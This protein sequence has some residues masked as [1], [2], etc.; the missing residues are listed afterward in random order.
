MFVMKEMVFRYCSEHSLKNA[1]QKNRHSSRYPPPCTAEA[2]LNSV[3][4]Y[5]KR[6]R[7]RTVSSS[8]QHSDEGRSSTPDEGAELKVTRSLDPFGMFPI[9]KLFGWFFV[10]LCIG[11]LIHFF[12][13]FVY[14]KKRKELIFQKTI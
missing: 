2:L 3:T 1:L 14:G 12:V 10:R 13:S 9:R 11:S 5:V 4:H 8:T 7:S 6:P